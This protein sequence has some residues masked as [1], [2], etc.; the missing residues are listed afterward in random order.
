MSGK[1]SSKIN[2]YAKKE[3]LQKLAE[4]SEKLR[5]LGDLNV[6]V[7]KGENLPNL[8]ASIQTA[9]TNIEPLLAD[10]PVKSNELNRLTNDVKNLHKEVSGRN[11]EI[12]ELATKTKELKEKTEKLIQEVQ[13]Q[14]GL[15]ANA[16]LASTFEAVKGELSEEKKNWFGW[17]AAAVTILVVAT[18]LVVWWQV[19]EIGTLYHLSFPIRLALLSPVVY[20]V[21][22]VNRE[23]NR[24]R[25]LIEEYTF[26]AALAR[27]FEAYKEVVQSVD[28][29]TSPIKTLAFIL[30]SI[31]SLYSSPMVNI[32][33]NTHKEKENAQGILSSAHEII[34]DT[35]TDKTRDQ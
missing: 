13:A 18:G 9:K 17:L 25:S 7:Q 23:Y 2:Y 21:V 22:F 5:A 8:I 30:E 11:E 6:L 15:A 32:K 27:S 26:K 16:K 19:K 33:N 35:L 34:K 31:K 24:V 10:L 20:F 12:V 29:E 3:L 28:S 1:L 4:I 14:L